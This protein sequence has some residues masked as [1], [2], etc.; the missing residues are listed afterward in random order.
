MS[1]AFG[2]GG[3]VRHGDKN[4]LYAGAA[5]VLVVA[6]VG[7]AIALIS[8]GKNNEAGPST[9]VVERGPDIQFVEVLIP[10]KDIEPATP[11]EPALFRKDKRPGIGLPERTIHDFEEIK[12]LFA[13]SLI[14]GNQPFARD[15]VTNVKPNS[16][17]SARIPEGYRAVTIKVDV[18]T[19]VEGFVRP[20]SRVDV[21]WIS[22]VN[23]RPTLTVIVQNAQV[24]SVERSEKSDQAQAGAPVPSTATLLVTA[25]DAQKIQLASIEGSLT[26]SL[27]GDSDSGKTA[28]STEVNIQDVL[29]PGSREQRPSVQ[30]N[31]T[32]KMGN[33]EYCVKPG[34]KL[35]PITQ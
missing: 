19:A 5:L 23:G 14:I 15:F 13:R 35:E 2:G 12:G 9:T 11:L 3:P 1:R 6:C 18:R 25:A 28:D 21:S 17:V 34:G 26:L 10:V 31:G 27:R 22:N 33:Q 16:G 29:Q 32:L 20:G 8:G 4:K 7:V 24:L 30:C